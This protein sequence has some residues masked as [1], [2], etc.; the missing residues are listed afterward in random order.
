MRTFFCFELP[1]GVKEELADFAREMDSPARVKWVSEDNLHVTAKFLGEIREGRVGEIK[2]V[3]EGVADGSEPFDFTVDKLGGF[4]ELSFPKVIWC[5]SRNPPGP[6]FDC[7]KNLEERMAEL[8]FERE[9]REYVP[10]I[11]LGRT[12][13]RSK[14]RIR[15]LGD[16]LEEASWG[17][18]RVV[19][20]RE[21]TLMESD[22]RPQGPVYEPLFRLP[23]D[24]S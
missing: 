9:D 6:I 16:E 24:G 7:Q 17:E 12:K 19:R 5:G 14:S 15:R 13:E 23:L 22:L 4:P 10:H 1:A 20:I 2:D 18:G 21:L 3:A 8:G 11:T